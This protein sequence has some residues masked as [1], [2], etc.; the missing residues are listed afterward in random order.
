[1]LF[2][3][4]RIVIILNWLIYQWILSVTF[5]H[6]FIYLQMRLSPNFFIVIVG[7]IPSCDSPWSKCPRLVRKSNSK[8]QEKWFDGNSNENSGFLHPVKILI[9]FSWE[10][11][12]PI[13]LYLALYLHQRLFLLLIHIFS[14]F[15]Y[16]CLRMIWMPNSTAQSCNTIQYYQYI[17]GI[18]QRN[19][20]MPVKQ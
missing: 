2:S 12:N 10:W 3:N 19:I 11:V 15:W 8:S 14:V 1:M 16:S 20:A 5:N 6:S 17:S 18:L 9:S 4:T 7:R 13:N